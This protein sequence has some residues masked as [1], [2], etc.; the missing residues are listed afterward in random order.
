LDNVQLS[1]SDGWLPYAGGNN[2]PFIAYPAI[3]RGGTSAPQVWAFTVPSR[4]TAFQF[5]VIVS[6]Q[7]E[8]PA[9]P[10]GVDGD[11]NSGNGSPRSIVRTLAGSTTGVNG[12]ID[13]GGTNAR[14][15]AIAGVSHDSAGNTFVA[16]ADNNAIRR[17]TPDGLVSTVAGSIGSA[18]YANG[19]GNVAELDAPHDV[20][21]VEGDALSSICGWPVGT[22]GVH[23]LIADLGNERIRIARGP[24]AGW[25]TDTPWEPWNPGFYEV[26]TV[27]GDGTAA[28]TNGSGAVA[29]FVAPASIA[30]GP[31]GIFYVLER[32]GGNRV[33]TLRW[34]GGD[35]TSPANWQV[36]LLAGSTAGTSG[37]IDATGSSA[38]FNQPRGIAVGPDGMVYVADTYNHCIRKITPDGDVS[39]LA[40]T[41]TSGYLDAAGSAARF[42]RPWDVCVGSDGYVY[43]A[44]RY[45]SRI[46]RVSPS[47]VVTTVAGTGLSLRLDGRGN[48]SAHTSDLGIGISPSGDL[49]VGEATCLRVI[50]R[51]IDV[52]G[53]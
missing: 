2:R 20:I 40:G 23:L 41:D 7:T 49:Y 52:G 36:D 22:D 28:Y 12:Y 27:A 46:R 19:R 14:F 17:V 16:D 30:M 38:R 26:S 3:G 50:E 33:R 5:S 51:I 31:G 45:N 25:T 48:E 42:F 35:P 37:Y 53:S 13:G 47:G 21:V 15:R 18:G 9:P 44:D 43:V 11:M 1:N 6:A 39:T 24:Y 34:T 4:V 29:Q 10:E 8:A 32:G